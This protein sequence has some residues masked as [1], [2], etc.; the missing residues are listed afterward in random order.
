MLRANIAMMMS[1][2]SLPV[3]GSATYADFDGDGYTDVAIFRN[4]DW[5]IAPSSGNC[6][7]AGLSSVP[8]HSG[9][10]KQWGLP[11]DKPLVGDFSGD[12]K[13]DL[14]VYRPSN[15]CWYINYTN[16]S[17]PFTGCF[18]GSIH[19]RPAVTEYVKTGYDDGR[20][21]I[22]WY[23]PDSHTTY[24]RSSISG[25]VQSLSGGI[26]WDA[27]WEGGVQAVYPVLPTKLVSFT[28]P[29]RLTKR[30][31]NGIQLFSWQVNHSTSTPS[32][33]TMQEDIYVSIGFRENRPLSILNQYGYKL[34][35]FF[36]RA[37]GIWRMYDQNRILLVSI[38]WGLNGDIPLT[39]DFD[40]DGVR[41]IGVYRYN[42]PQS[43]FA[44][45]YVL[46]SSGLPPPTPGPG[47]L[48]WQSWYG[49]YRI[50][51][52]LNGDIP[53]GSDVNQS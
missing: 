5:W 36:N 3:F 6:S 51:W 35:L 22:V 28:E 46:T 26:P 1:M 38:Q 30:L 34:F 18:G 45:F 27:I 33:Y 15:K 13:A 20:S 10:Y 40:G 19:N 17:S 14:A 52:G 25:S 47:Q 32:I 44:T 23:D 11:G 42:D 53:I 7:A 21:D 37:N 24:L 41:D 49:G 12:G 39:G 2:M 43:G 31:S 48:N 50:Q 4:G 8:G 16:G 29:D 9:C